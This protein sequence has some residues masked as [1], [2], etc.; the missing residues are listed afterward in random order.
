MKRWITVFSIVSVS[1]LSLSCAQKNIFQE[2]HPYTRDGVH[3][4]GM[5]HIGEDDFFYGTW[6]APRLGSDKQFHRILME[7]GG[8]LD[9]YLPQK[10]DFLV[11]VRLTHELPSLRIIVNDHPIHFSGNHFRRK[12]SSVHAISG[13]NSLRFV[14]SG[15]DRI[16]IQAVHIYPVRFLRVEDVFNPEEDCLTPG[17]ILMFMNPNK[18]AEIRLVLDF[19]GKERIEAAIAIQTETREHVYKQFIKKGRPFSIVPLDHTIQKITLEIP[20]TKAGWIKILKSEIIQ[21]RGRHVRW[22][23]LASALEEKNILFLLLDAARADRLGCYGYPR[24]TSPNIDELAKT[25]FVFSDATSE[26]AYTLA[27]TGTL[28][29]GLPPDFHGVVSA[30]FNTLNE[31]IITFPELLREN[32]YFT[33]AV[34]SNP[35]FSPRYNYHQGFEHFVELFQKKDAVQAE[36]FIAPFKNLI[37]RK[38]GKPFF[39]YLHI[40]EPHSPYS[41][42]LPFFGRYQHRYEKPSSDF[43][44]EANRIERGEIEGPDDFAFLSDVYDE[45]LAYADHIVGMLMDVLKSSGKWEETVVVVLS[46]HGEALGEHGYVGHNSILYQEGIRI[47]LLIRI[48]GVIEKTEVLDDPVITSD[49]VITLCDLLGLEYPY[50]GE[51]RGRNF[52]LSSYRRDRI[53]RS[54]NQSSNYAGY[55]VTSFPYKLIFFPEL[56]TWDI[57]LFN[58]EEDPGEK[59]D[60][61]GR[62]HV[63]DALWSEFRNFIRSASHGMQA[64]QKPRLSKEEIE[65]LKTLG[66]IKE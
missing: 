26:A 66:Y 20:E 43:Y 6:S 21:L 37:E 22:K 4:F 18:D 38:K 14:F 1:L 3:I 36:E 48:P 30:F 13:E 54:M 60:L 63:Q 11:D 15:Q 39:L 50:P 56:D 8:G 40:R 31:E 33:A 52:F 58:I 62:D 19:P 64:G 5:N 42:P 7:S 41:M 47:P 61:E 24:Q 53:C 16:G 9:F 51:T 46:D 65:A 25:G 12:I 2:H 23:R 59:E 32:G 44:Y 49:I 57:E 28:L 45:N 34:S 29:T 10:E 35:Y 17:S 27:S 55:S